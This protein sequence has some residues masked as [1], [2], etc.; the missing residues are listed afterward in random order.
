MLDLDDYSFFSA[1]KIVELR[2]NHI[3]KLFRRVFFQ[4]T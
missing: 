4:V 3:I 1:E 2:F